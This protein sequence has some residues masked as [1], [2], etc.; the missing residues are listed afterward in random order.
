[1]FAAFEFRLQQ[2]DRAANHAAL[3][4]NQTPIKRHAAVHGRE[5]A[6][7]SFAPD[8]CGLNGR[9][10]LQN[11]QQRKHGALRE[12][13][14]L[15]ETAGLADDGSELELDGLKMRV[16]PPAAGSLQGAEQPIA[17]PM[18]SLTFGH[19]VSAVRLGL[20]LVALLR[21]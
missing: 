7:C 5:Q 21:E 19:A 1:M 20:G 6:E 9:P 16:D 4:L 13:G 12:I 3:Q 18:I 11:S 15:E 2:F 8:V 17:P 10:V 14:V